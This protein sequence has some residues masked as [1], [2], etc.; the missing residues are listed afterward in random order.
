MK[1]AFTQKEYARLLEM[2]HIAT[3]VAGSHDDQNPAARRYANL[4]QKL[5]AMATPMGC[6]DYVDADTDDGTLYPSLKLEEET[7][8][9]QAIDA[10]DDATFWESLA[11]RLAKRDY[12][13]ELLKEPLPKSL[14]DDERHAHMAKR[15]DA[16]EERYWGEFEKHGLDNLMVLFGTE[17]LS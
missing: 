1:I 8:A 11:T 9:T 6:A 2:S 4:E 13:R 10:Y 16:L 15:L 14:S 7:P 12:T 17:R 5:L 3:W